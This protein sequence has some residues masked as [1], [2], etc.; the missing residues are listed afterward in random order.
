ME[1][2]KFFLKSMKMAYILWNTNF[3]LRGERYGFG[4][5]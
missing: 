3:A 4:S 1:K 2:Q 5:K